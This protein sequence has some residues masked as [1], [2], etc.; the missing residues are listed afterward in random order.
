MFCWQ[1]LIA[2]D[3]LSD[4]TVRCGATRSE[5][6]LV[7]HIVPIYCG[8][9]QSDMHRKPDWLVDWLASHTHIETVRPESA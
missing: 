1:F 8:H 9:L 2:L 6:Q 4:S 7:E 5:R 3:L